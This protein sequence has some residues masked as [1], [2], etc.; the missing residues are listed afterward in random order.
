MPPRAYHS[1]CDSIVTR[2]LVGLGFVYLTF[3]FLSGNG[4]VE[5]RVGGRGALGDFRDHMVLE[6]AFDFG[7]R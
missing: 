1:V 7:A 4:L 3:D 5:H 2:G 6:V